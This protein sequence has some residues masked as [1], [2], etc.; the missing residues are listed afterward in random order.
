MT[1]LNTLTGIYIYIYLA[2]SCLIPPVGQLDGLSWR[3]PTRL[4]PCQIPSQIKEKG[5][6]K[7]PVVE[8]LINDIRTTQPWHDI[9][10]WLRTESNSIQAASSMVFIENY[11]RTQRPCFEN[12]SIPGARSYP[13]WRIFFILVLFKIL[14]MAIK[15]RKLRNILLCHREALCTFMYIRNT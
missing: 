1:I 15:N 4:M 5:W 6:G 9:S 12:L 14:A 2:L 3:R 8:K 13:K 10:E 7:Y 11:I